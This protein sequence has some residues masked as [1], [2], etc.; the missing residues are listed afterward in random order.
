MLHRKST[1]V[2]SIKAEFSEKE[3]NR[4]PLRP[5]SRRVR[6]SVVQEIRYLSGRMFQDLLLVYD[7]N[8]VVVV[9]APAA[10]RRTVH[11]ARVVPA[12]RVLTVM[13]HH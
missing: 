5:F 13:I 11:V 7:A 10:A 6:S 12:V 1:L 3:K 9:A 8:D 2:R 4:F